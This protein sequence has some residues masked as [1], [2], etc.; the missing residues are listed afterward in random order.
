MMLCGD[1]APSD[2]CEVTYLCIDSTVVEL[3]IKLLTYYNYLYVLSTINSST[4]DSH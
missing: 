1:D 4:L 3:I 2:S